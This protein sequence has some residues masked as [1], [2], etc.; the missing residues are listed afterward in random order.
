MSNWDPDI[1]GIKALRAGAVRQIGKHFLQVRPHSA[2]S[3]CCE[4][5]ESCRQSME[6]ALSGKVADF[7]GG[8]GNY[9]EQELADAAI[10]VFGELSPLEA[11]TP[12][13]VKTQ[14]QEASAI[15]SEIFNRSKAITATGITSTKK[16]DANLEE[17]REAAKAMHDK[18]KYKQAQQDIAALEARVNLV[19]RFGKQ[20]ANTDPAS[21]SHVV[22]AN[23]QFLGYKDGRELLDHLQK[24]PLKGEPCTRQCQRWRAAIDAVKKMAKE[25]KALATFNKENGIFYYNR[26]NAGGTRTRKSGD[27]RIGGNDFMEKSPE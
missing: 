8:I 23:T 15:A 19:K 5:C 2:V 6:D 11:K 10:A 25:P 16:E 22:A 9:T 1:L 17:M 27:V 26:S 4:D 3:T 21:L 14:T 18:V 7:S 13:T 24:N 12:T 20:Y